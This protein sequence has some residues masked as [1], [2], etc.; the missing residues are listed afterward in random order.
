M[1]YKIDW[2]DPKSF[3]LSRN[4]RE[5]KREMCAAFNVEEAA[6]DIA[7]LKSCPHFTPES[8]ANENDPTIYCAFCWAIGDRSVCEA[9]PAGS[10]EWR[11]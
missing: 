3:E 7:A 1:T 10:T 11:D 8:D 6:E 9:R 4:V 5:D 2:D